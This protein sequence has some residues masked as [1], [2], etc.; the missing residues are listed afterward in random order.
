MG[1]RRVAILVNTQGGDLEGFVKSARRKVKDNVKLPPGTHLDWGGTFE[2]LQTARARLA[3][4]SPLALVLV[5][6]M[7]YAAFRDWALSLLV[8]AGVPLALFGGIVALSL[9]G[10]P[11]SI[12]AAVGFIAL[13]GIA[14]LNGMV[15]TSTY[16]QLRKDGQAAAEAVRNAAV[17][18]LRPVLMTALV[19]IFGF[20]PMMFSG[21]MGA[22]VQ[23]PLATV[24]VGGVFSATFLTLLTLPA[25]QLWL[26]RKREDKRTLGA[27][28]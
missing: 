2:N 28:A 21:G 12:S 22:E 23:R 15:L 7:V 16:V 3:V 20:L 6:L 18:R 25:W 24:V 9:R 8:F 27:R 14:V 11:F 5:F 13:A 10:L 17:G 26:D 4:L 19:E 1:Q